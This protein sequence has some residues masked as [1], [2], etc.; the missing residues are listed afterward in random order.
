MNSKLTTVVFYICCHWL[1]FRFIHKINSKE[2]VIT[3]KLARS[4][5]LFQISHLIN[6]GDF[7]LPAGWIC[8][9]N[10]RLAVIESENII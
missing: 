4:H 7:N 9:I 6:F 10:P 2:N 5:R 1:T 8:V 3:Y